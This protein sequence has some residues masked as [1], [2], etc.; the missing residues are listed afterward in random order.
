MILT[1]TLSVHFL[2]HDPDQNNKVLI[3]NKITAESD[4]CSLQ[5]NFYLLFWCMMVRNGL[6]YCQVYNINICSHQLMEECIFFIIVN[7]IIKYM[8]LVRSSRF[9]ATIV[10]S[11]FETWIQ[12]P[13]RVWNSGPVF[14]FCLFIYCF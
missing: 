13:A 2:S 11:E 12:R 14:L 8:K 6:F 9:L 5:P 3:S 4:A 7:K 1:R 10:I